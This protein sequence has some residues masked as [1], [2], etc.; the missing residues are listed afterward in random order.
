MKNDK[1]LTHTS[2]GRFILELFDHLIKSNEE[3]KSQIAAEIFSKLE[4]C[5]PAEGEPFT[6]NGA[7]K[8]W[9]MFHKLRLSE[10]MLQKW[11]IF[12]RRSST[13]SSLQKYGRQSLQVTLD[14]GFKHLIAERNSTAKA[15]NSKTTDE[16]IIS[17]REENVVRYMSG[18]VAVK[19][20]KK[21][22]KGNANGV[23]KNKWRYFVRV[24]SEMKCED[25]PLCNDTVEDYT[26]A[27]SEQIDRGGLYHVKPEVSTEIT[28]NNI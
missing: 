4:S 6:V 23:V 8:M 9:S 21:Y 28:T 22:R 20:L 14:R 3:L 16:N 18:Y 17:E 24:L 25:Q 13:T 27:W 26:K 2:R 12:I 10:D 11:N 5:L 7:D 1:V 15:T 19:L